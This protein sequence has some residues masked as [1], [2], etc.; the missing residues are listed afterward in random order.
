MNPP[1]E[2]P[3]IPIR[4]LST[5][6]L[7]LSHVIAVSMSSSSCPPSRRYAVHALT[8]PFPEAGRGSA[9]NTTKPAEHSCW[10][11]VLRCHASET[12]GA[13]GPAYV[14]NHTGYLFAGSKSAGLVTEPSIRNPSGV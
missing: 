5:H 9:R 4:P 1:Y 3:D 10:S 14:W 11:N 12:V 6:G 8:A 13:C 7:A 2:C